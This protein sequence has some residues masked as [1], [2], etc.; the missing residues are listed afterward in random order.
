MRVYVNDRK[1]ELAPGMKIRHALLQTGL[2]SE[3]ERGKKRVYD[4]WGNEAGIDGSL[5]EDA[6]IYVR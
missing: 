1:I 6:R 3:V 4:R 5:T 2:M